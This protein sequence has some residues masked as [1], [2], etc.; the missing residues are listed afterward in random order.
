MVSLN[1]EQ[2][3]SLEEKQANAFKRK[4]FGTQKKNLESLV[5]CGASSPLTEI[6]SVGCEVGAHSF[7]A[8]LLVNGLQSVRLVC[9]F[10]PAE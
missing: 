9:L 2:T 6:P 3:A 4:V 10:R 7:P 1:I 8:S 5:L